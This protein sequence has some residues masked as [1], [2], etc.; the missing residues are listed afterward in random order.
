MIDYISFLLQI[1]NFTNCFLKNYKI[2][3][4]PD[5]PNYVNFN[6]FLLNTINFIHLIPGYC[7][8]DIVL[9]ILITIVYLKLYLSI[10]Y[11]KYHLLIYNMINSI[12]NVLNRISAICLNLKILNFQNFC[13]FMYHISLILYFKSYIFNNTILI[14]L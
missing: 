6:N 8:I 3:I 7:L 13:L 5:I 4:V 14:I 10:S 11:L 2:N 12:L 9:R 1:I